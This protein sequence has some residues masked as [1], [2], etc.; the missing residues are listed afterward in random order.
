LISTTRSL[1]SRMSSDDMTFA[2]IIPWG[3][4]VPSFGDPLRSL[5][6]T[7]G[8]NPSN[9]E[10]V[11]QSGNELDG[12]SRRFHTLRSLGLTHWKRAKEEH[13]S[14]I[15]DSCRAYFSRNPYDGW[16][17]RLDR[18]ISGTG[19]SYYDESSAAC[20]LDLIPYATE[21]KWMELTNDQ[22][23]KL[24]EISGD[25]LG[26]LLSDSP[27][28]VLILN[29]RSVVQA[30]EKMAGVSLERRQMSGW[31]LPR[32]DQ[33]GVTGISYTGVIDRLSGID[34]GRQVSVLG[35]NHNIQ[36][37]F[38]VTTGVLNEIR[39]WIGRSFRRTFA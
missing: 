16:F 17:K 36:S 8:L 30:F 37:S 34:L 25:A 19:A 18:L 2:N 33:D 9:R 6:A 5:V 7:V 21:R 15:L 32:R 38:G 31:T 29:G 35:F 23:T 27:A 14:L 10:F 24:M 3:S 39:T 22:R 1:V 26:A 12:S 4:P 11:D 28:R 20:H 13:I